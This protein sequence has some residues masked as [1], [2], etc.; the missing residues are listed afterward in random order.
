MTLIA[1]L[2]QKQGERSQEQFAAELGIT[3]AMLS[4]VYS[5]KRQIGRQVAGKIARRYPD[6]AFEVAAFLLATDIPAEQTAIG[7]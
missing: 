5:G 7:A 1:S 3:Q 2:K 4:R 6:L